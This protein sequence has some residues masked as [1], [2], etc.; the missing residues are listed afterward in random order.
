MTVHVCTSE[1]GIRSDA[2]DIGRI[3]GDQ[4]HIT[5]LLAENEDSSCKHKKFVTMWLPPH[6]AV[7]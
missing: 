7:K 5:R 3:D 6:L 2:V 4:V 1:I